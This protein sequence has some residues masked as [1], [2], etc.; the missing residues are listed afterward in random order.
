MFHSPRGQRAAQRAE[1]R[2]S[3]V[4]VDQPKQTLDEPGRLPEGHPEQHLHCQAGL[5]GRVT[6]VRLAA[7]LAGRRGLPDHGGIE[8]AL[9]RLQTI[10]YRPTDRQRPAALER[11]I[12]GGPVSGLVGRGC[13]SAHA[14]QLPRWIHAMNPSQDLCNRAPWIPKVNQTSPEKANALIGPDPKR[15]FV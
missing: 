1:V 8:P 9:R 13:G 6:V 12:V 4:Q 11:L 2:H 10:A 14:I 5:D 3:P 7:T 15:R